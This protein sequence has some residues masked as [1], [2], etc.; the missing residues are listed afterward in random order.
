MSLSTLSRP[1]A[2]VTVGRCA[3]IPGD[4]PIDC[5][6][7]SGRR[8]GTVGAAPLNCTDSGCR[9]EGVRRCAESRHVSLLDD[10]SEIP[11]DSEL[12]G[13]VGRRYRRGAEI[14]GCGVG[15]RCLEDRY[16]AGA[17]NSGGN[18]SSGGGTG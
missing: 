16:C 11:E 1:L 6:L 10:G 17:E 4:A 18:S 8:A 15:R 7:I 2:T 9:A 14:V 5:T 12:V 13:G 3:G